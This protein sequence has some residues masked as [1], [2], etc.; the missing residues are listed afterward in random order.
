VFTFRL[1][2][3]LGE[4]REAFCNGERRK[5]AAL[6]IEIHKNKIHLNFVF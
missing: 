1:A 3:S 2:F 4:L 5:L 6:D